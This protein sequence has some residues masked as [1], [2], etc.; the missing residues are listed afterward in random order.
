MG[1]SMQGE[2]GLD[3][4][5]R[6]FLMQEDTQTKEGF[7]LLEVANLSSS[8]LFRQPWYLLWY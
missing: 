7:V 2:M 6:V 5:E 3:H 4:L 8:Q 1:P